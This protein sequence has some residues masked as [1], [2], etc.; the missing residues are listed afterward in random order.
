MWNNLMSAMDD[1]SLSLNLF[2]WQLKTDKHCLSLLWHFF[3]I[4]MWLTSV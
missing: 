1:E 4:L 3:L 2:K